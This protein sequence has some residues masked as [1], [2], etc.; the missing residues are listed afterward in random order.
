MK[1]IEQMLITLFCL[2]LGLKLLLPVLLSEP[3][4]ASYAIIGTWI[5]PFLLCLIYIS[6]TKISLHTLT[7]LLLGIGHL[8]VMFKTMHWPGAGI[9]LVVNLIA[10]LIASITLIRTGVLQKSNN[11]VL[12]GNLGLA[13]LMI[14]QLLIGTWTEFTDF[15]YIGKAMNY[16]TILSILIIL[17]GKLNEEINDRRLLKV[18]AMYSSVYVIGQVVLL[19]M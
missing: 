5:I 14:T 19:F 15:I 10:F 18:I 12:I 16:L 7:F 17:I 1:F 8:G 2:S 4:G 9:L 13:G 3:N 11:K 6:T